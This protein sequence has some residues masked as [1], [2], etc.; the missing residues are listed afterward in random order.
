[1]M[2]AVRKVLAVLRFR[3]GQGLVSRKNLTL[4]LLT[5]I[6][7]FSC[8]EPVG[9]FAG[10]LG[11]RARPWL[12]AHLINDY[13]I[14]MTLGCACVGLFCDAP[15]RDELREYVVVR[16]G[17][18]AESAGHVLYILVL[19][20]L[21]TLFVLVMSVLPII[22][23]TEF[24]G[25]WGKV[26]GT[27]SRTDP[28]AVG[29]SFPVSNYLIGSSDPLMATCLS[30]LLEWACFAFLGLVVYLF[31]RHGRHLRG[32][33]AGGFFVLLDLTAYNNLGSRFYRVS[34]LTLA[35]LTQFQGRNKLLF[36]I[37]LPYAARFFALSLAAL[38]A[39]IVMLGTSE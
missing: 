25:G 30:F 11:M 12:F 22:A 13:I 2:G 38:S 4:L 5:G 20:F 32:V 33:F 24:A 21:F 31:N 27:L 8:V 9:A 39:V 37:D 16:A 34:P 29:L 6:Y 3:L 18:R 1:M 26:L 23:K 14:Q 28:A 7:L 35:Q 10:S 17:R 15:W 36:G 19:S